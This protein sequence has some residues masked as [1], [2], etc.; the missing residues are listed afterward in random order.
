MPASS[1][2]VQKPVSSIQDAV[3]VFST[4]LDTGEIPLVL[5][6]AHRQS[7]N[8]WV[9]IP[10]GIFCLRQI[11]GKDAGVADVGAAFWPPGYRI[12]YIVTMQACTYNAPVRACPTQDNV[13]VHI[14]VVLTFAIRDPGKFVYKLG[15]VHFD[16]LLAGA[17][18]EGIR[19]LVRKQTHQTVRSLRGN[20]ADAMLAHLTNKFSES[21]VSFSACTITSVTLPDSLERSL[22]NT[23]EMDKAMKAAKRQQEYEVRQIE[24]A[25]D[26]DLNQ[27]TRQHENVIMQEQG[28]KQAAQN[29]HRKKLEKT[30]EELRV[31][32]INA[33]QDAEVKKMQLTGVLERTHK[34]MQLERNE[35]VSIAEAKAESVRVTAD[36]DFYKRQAEADA[37]REKMIG[38]A[39]S[40]R[41]DAE[42]EKTA[43]QHLTHKRRHLI[44]MREKDVIMKL[45]EKSKFNLIGGAGDTLVDAVMTGKLDPRGSKGAASNGAGSGGWFK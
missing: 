27:L 36:N 10:T 12:A 14:D 38:E 31:A 6:P 19:L 40:I 16:Q 29:Y 37:E 21:G 13:R 30:T 22:E 33:Q 41:L 28:K 4:K 23:T 43:S 25:A 26:M 34:S 5:V 44:D 11:F 24:Q 15:A 32:M 17:V 20:R 7:W 35:G 45:A 2:C 42:A 39:E 9:T 1:R 8:L 18:D 3:S